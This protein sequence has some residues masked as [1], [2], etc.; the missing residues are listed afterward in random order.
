MDSF[1]E[2]QPRK[3][4]MSKDVER[5]IRLELAKEKAKSCIPSINKDTVIVAA[6]AVGAAIAGLVGGKILA[7][8]L[9]P[10]LREK[11]IAPEIFE[12]NATIEEK[13]ITF[14]ECQEY[15]RAFRNN[16][17][18][19][20]LCEDGTWALQVADSGILIDDDGRAY[21]RMDEIPGTLPE[22]YDFSHWAGDAY[23]DEEFQSMARKACY[24]T[25]GGLGCDIRYL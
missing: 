7:D 22:T 10:I 14:G 12:V 21:E 8:K 23:Y 15:G 24:Y 17:G 4:Q 13:N 20:Y 11:E 16:F 9:S 3:P 1:Q 19:V 6:S 18:D 5:R 25:A 2:K